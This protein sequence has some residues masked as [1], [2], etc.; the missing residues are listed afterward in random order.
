LIS[1]QFKLGIIKELIKIQLLF[2]SLFLVKA[3]FFAKFSKFDEKC[4]EKVAEDGKTSKQI[5]M[6]SNIFKR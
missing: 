6:I 3:V 2:L 5:G 4:K 1:F